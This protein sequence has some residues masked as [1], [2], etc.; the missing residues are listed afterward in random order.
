MSTNVLDEN[1]RAAL[2]LMQNPYAKLSLIE[3]KEFVSTGEEP[4]MEQKKAY[5]RKLQNP[6]AHSSIFDEPGQESQ[7]G[8][9]PGLDPGKVTRVSRLSKKQFEDDCRRIFLQ[10]IP[11]AE[12]RVLRPHHREFITRNANRSPEQRFRLLEE[13]A[14]YD[15][16][17]SGNFKPHFNRE[18]ELFTV[19]KLREI[20]KAVL[21]SAKS[22]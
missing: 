8:T 20:E 17:T 18:R 7:S 2:R 3:D 1:V 12:G 15:I 21:A 22:V 4:T 11:H 14:K 5:F 13:L 10:Y 9:T 16:S 6:H 19:K